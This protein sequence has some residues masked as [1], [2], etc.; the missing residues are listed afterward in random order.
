MRQPFGQRRLEPLAAQLVAGQPDGLKHRQH[1]DGIIDD[2]GPAP[3]GRCRAQRT[4]QQPQGGFGMIP[5]QGAKRRQDARLVRRTGPLAA[6]VDA[7]QTLA[8]GR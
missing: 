8:F 6:A 1:H 4:V 5:A 3:F 7:R 2:F